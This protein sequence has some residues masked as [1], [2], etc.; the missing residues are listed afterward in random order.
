MNVGFAAIAMVAL[1][2]LAFGGARPTALVTALGLAPL[3]IDSGQAGREI[4]GPMAVVILGG[5][6]SS[7]LMSLL[8]LPVPILRWRQPQKAQANIIR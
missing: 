5:L 4:Q 3:A 1:R 7:T 8:F 2:A 6:I